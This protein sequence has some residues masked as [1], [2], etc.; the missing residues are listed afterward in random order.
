M[1]DEKQ[2][3]EYP[4]AM[5]GPENGYAV[6]TSKEEEESL[7]EGWISGHDYWAAKAAVEPAEK[8][9]RGRKANKPES[10]EQ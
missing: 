5:H 3:H 1:A 6:V 9:G 10:T 2:F 7:G 4:K 8:K